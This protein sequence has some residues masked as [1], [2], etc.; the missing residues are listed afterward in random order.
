MAILCRNRV[1]T[2]YQRHVL[3]NVILRLRILPADGLL[4]RTRHLSGD[5]NGDGLDGVGVF[6][7]SGHTSVLKNATK[8]TTFKRGMGNDLP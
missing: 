5:W 1:K 2:W 8:N 3:P 6:R 7:Q 4:V